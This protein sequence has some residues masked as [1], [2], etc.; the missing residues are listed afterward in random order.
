[1]FFNNLLVVVVCAASHKA[2]LQKH[3]FLSEKGPNYGTNNDD[4][5]VWGDKAQRGAHAV[6]QII[7]R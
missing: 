1:M 2:K 6:K 3:T 4:K 7:R 5:E